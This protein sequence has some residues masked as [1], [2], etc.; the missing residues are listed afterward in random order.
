MVNDTTPNSRTGPRRVGGRMRLPRSR[1]RDGHRLSGP[2]VAG[3]SR[4]IGVRPA[5]RRV[6]VVFLPG[7][8]GVT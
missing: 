5:R 8:F 3:E 6:P 7:W 4:Y 2:V 1:G